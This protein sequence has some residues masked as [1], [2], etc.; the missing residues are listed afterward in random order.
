MIPPALKATAP[1]GPQTIVEDSQQKES[2]TV[3]TKAFIKKLFP[4]PATPTIFCLNGFG[5]I[6]W[7]ILF[8][9]ILVSDAEYKQLYFSGQ[10]KPNQCYTLYHHFILGDQ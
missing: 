6:F 3:V 4:H 2:H 7:G 5:L 9:S 8:H 1:V 10:G